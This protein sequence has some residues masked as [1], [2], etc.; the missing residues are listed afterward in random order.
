MI[1]ALARWQFI[2]REGMAVSA[3]PIGPTELGRNAN[4]VFAL[5]AVTIPHICRAGKKWTTFSGT[6]PFGHF[7]SVSYSFC[8][9]F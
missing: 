6:T 4:Y 3:A 5:R 7:D 2:D 1:F 9:P 8:W